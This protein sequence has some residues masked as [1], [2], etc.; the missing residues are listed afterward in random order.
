MYHVHTIKYH[1]YF[2]HTLQVFI[3]MNYVF[4]NNYWPLKSPFITL[5]P[6]SI[7]FSW[8]NLFIRLCT[9]CPLFLYKIHAVTY[10]PI[11]TQWKKVD[12]KNVWMSNVF[13]A[14][15]RCPQYG[16]AN[17]SNVHT[18]SERGIICAVVRNT[19]LWCASAH[20]FHYKA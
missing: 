6:E 3:Y 1:Q 10:A 20:T 12:F 16:N 8:S 14:M 17:K 11:H 4:F 9:H 5:L 13:F 2:V 18:C 19:T 15:L 7:V